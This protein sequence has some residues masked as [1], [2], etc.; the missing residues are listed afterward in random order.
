[1]CFYL[2]VWYVGNL[3]LVGCRVNC[4]KIRDVYWDLCVDE[5]YYDY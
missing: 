2:E 5:I 3:K 4:Y 1:M